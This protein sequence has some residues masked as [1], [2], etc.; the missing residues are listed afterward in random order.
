ME[1]AVAGAQNGLN[2]AGEVAQSEFSSVS[3]DTTLEE[4]LH[5]VAEDETP[6]AVLDEEQ[7]L[8]GI[9]TRSALLQAIQSD[10]TGNGES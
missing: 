7:H 8:L 5:P 2:R 9:I 3:P 4:C 6:V 1:Q 10:T